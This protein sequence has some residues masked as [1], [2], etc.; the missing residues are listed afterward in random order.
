LTKP[1]RQEQ[2]TDL[3]QTLRPSAL[4]EFVGQ[5]NIVENLKVSSWQHASEMNRSIMF[6]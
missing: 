5:E 4:T 1:E 2:E 3:D 6:F